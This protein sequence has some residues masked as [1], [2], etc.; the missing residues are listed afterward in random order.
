[1]LLLHGDTDDTVYPENVY[2]LFERAGEPKEIQLLPGVG[3]R[4]RQEETAIGAALEWLKERLW[5]PPRLSIYQQ[6]GL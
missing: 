1:M 3:H 4:F 5:R 6:T 2:T